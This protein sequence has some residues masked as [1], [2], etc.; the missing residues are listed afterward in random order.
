MCQLPHRWKSQE[1][2]SRTL[3]LPTFSFFGVPSAKTPYGSLGKLPSSFPR[4]HKTKSS[5]PS[6]GSGLCV[7]LHLEKSVEDLFLK[8]SRV[9]MTVHSCKPSYPRKTKQ[10]DHKFKTGLGYM[11]GPR[12]AW[13]TKEDLVSKKSKL[14]NRCLKEYRSKYKD[15][16]TKK[17]VFINKE[18]EDCRVRGPQPH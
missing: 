7:R 15:F 5:F 18:C 12:S 10:K 1:P 6:Y 16:N 8:N 11:V 14:E 3:G 4:L 9:D 13:A 17:R 2:D